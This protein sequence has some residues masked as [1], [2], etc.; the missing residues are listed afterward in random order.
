[1]R[2]AAPLTKPRRHDLHTGRINT[3]E[4]NT[5]QKAQKDRGRGLVY[6]ET[7]S[8]I[9]SSAEKSGDSEEMPGANDVRK[10]ER[11]ADERAGDEA[12]LNGDRD[13]A[14]LRGRQLPLA[15][16]RRD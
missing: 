15:R 10:I 16:Q 6:V 9:S 1:E 2:H 4:T 3:G 5:N 8:E 13:P 14:Y 11:G 7:E 12:E